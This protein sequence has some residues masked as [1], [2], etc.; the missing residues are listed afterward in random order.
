MSIETIFL[1]SVITRFQYYKEL[2][3]KTFAR[4]E[5]K[6]FNHQPDGEPNSIAIIIQHVSGNMISRWTNFLTEDGEKPW[7]NRDG[8][9]ISRLLTKQQ[10]LEMWE[11]GWVC[12]FNILDNLTGDDLLKTVHIRHEPHVALDAIIRQLSHYSYHAGQIVYIGK[13]IEGEKWINLSIAKGK[14]EEFNERKKKES[15]AG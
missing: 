14:S 6:D 10:L 9:F 1:Q 11:K 7:R 13:M 5:D 4:L 3:D 15:D 2:G 8:E 12:M